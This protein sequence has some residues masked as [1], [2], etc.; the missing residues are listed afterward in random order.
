MYCWRSAPL[1]CGI[2]L[3]HYRVISRLAKKHMT[4]KARDALAELLDPNERIAD[5]ADMGGFIKKRPPRTPPCHYVDV[6]L[7]EPAYHARW[8]GKDPKNGLV[9]DKIKEFKATLKNKSKPVEERRRVVR[10]LIQSIEDMHQ[11]CH[12][13][14]NEDRGANDTQVRFFDRGTNM[15][16]LWDGA[17]LAQMSNEEDYCLKGL[18]VPPMALAQDAAAGMV[19]IGHGTLIAARKCT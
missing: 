4:E 10:F 14:N 13:G 2:G 16:S 9:V 3:D 11:P 12:V 1:L 19:E 17:L 15:H 6:P 8:S 7:D 18:T 5:G